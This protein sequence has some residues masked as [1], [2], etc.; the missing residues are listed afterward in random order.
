MFQLFVSGRNL[1]KSVNLSEFWLL[2]WKMQIIVPTFETIEGITGKNK[3]KADTCT[4][5]YTP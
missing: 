3:T 1:G 5:I 2:N 4:Y